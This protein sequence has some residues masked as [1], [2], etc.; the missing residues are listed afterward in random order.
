MREEPGRPLPATLAEALRPKRLLLVLDNCEHL[1]DACARLADELLRACPHL[2]VLATSRE[3]LGVAGEAPY[4]VPSLAVPGPDARPPAET[5]A[6]YEAVRLF[7]ARAAVVQ[8]AFAVTTQNARAV[9]AV[10]RRLDGIPLALELAAARVRVLPVQ[11]LHAR[12]EDRFR[13]L[14]GG[15]RTALARHQTLRAAIDWSYDLLTDQ[16][17]TLFARLAVFAGGFTLEAAEAVCAGDPCGQGGTAPRPPR[18]GRAGPAGEAGDVLELLTRLVDKSL[19]QVD[20]QADGAARYRLLET[21][22]EYAR[23]RLEASGEAETLAAGHAD[24]YLPREEAPPEEVRRQFGRGMG[25]IRPAR[26]WLAQELDNV[27]AALRWCLEQGAAERALTFAIGPLWGIWAGGGHRAEG[28]RWVTACLAAGT[29]L[30]AWLRTAGHLG[31][32]LSAQY[33][34]DY[35]ESRAHLER[36]VALRRETGEGPPGAL[37]VLGIA[38]WLDGDDAGAAEAIGESLPRPRPRGTPRRSPRPCAT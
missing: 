14:T 11:H 9:A 29:D 26:A 2:T 13:L 10:C 21:L 17:R 23:E 34:G 18:T 33:M 7:A 24:Y 19:V 5:L 38:R 30:P 15:P 35:A 28:R 32:G 16:E 27:R 8:P 6:Q 1:L 20:D 25:L 31:A 12:L 37:S 3:A 22:R 4:R 36:S